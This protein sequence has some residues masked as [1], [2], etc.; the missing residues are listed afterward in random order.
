MYLVHP[1]SN[2][3]HSNEEIAEKIFQTIK[4]YVEKNMSH[5]VGMADSDVT[6]QAIYILDSIF[7]LYLVSCAGQGVCMWTTILDLS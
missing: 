7:I 1:D 5:I 3:P 2:I 4:P 6:W